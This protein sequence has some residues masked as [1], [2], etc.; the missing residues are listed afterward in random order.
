MTP[1]DTLIAWAS[2]GGFAATHEAGATEGAIADDLLRFLADRGC[3]IVD[4]PDTT[5][6]QAFVGML[7]RAGVVFQDLTDPHTGN[8]TVSVGAHG[9]AYSVF[10]GTTGA[11]MR[12]GAGVQLC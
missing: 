12:V 6:L 7:T 11:L 10:S 2:S 4:G 8:H 3:W 5:D 9:E 1:R